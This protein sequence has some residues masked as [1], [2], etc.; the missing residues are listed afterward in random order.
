MF[1]RLAAADS[2]FRLAQ[3]LGCGPAH[4]SRKGRC[5]VNT[6]LH[7]PPHL[8]P[9]GN[10]FRN[11]RGEFM[12]RDQPLGQSFRLVCRQVGWQVVLERRNEQGVDIL[13]LPVARPQ[14]SQ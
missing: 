12:R 9:F 11:R 1:H 2:R 8:P 3:E 6:T 14:G 5:F 10:D 7:I 13:V 4:L